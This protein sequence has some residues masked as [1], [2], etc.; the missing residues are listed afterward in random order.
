[1]KRYC[2]NCY[3]PLPKKA[4]FCVQCGQKNSDGKVRMRAMLLKL[5][6]TTFHLEGKF[7]RTCWQLFIPGKVTQEVFKGKQSR[8]PHPIRMFAIMMFLFLF[9]V[10]WVL[11]D[12]DANNEG[13]LISINNSMSAVNGDSTAEHKFSGSFYEKMRHRAMLEDMRAD[14]DALPSNWK[15]PAARKAVDSLL[16]SSNLRKG[17][18]ETGLLDSLELKED[19]IKILKLKGKE[20]R[21]AMMDLVRYE[22]DELIDRYAISE[23]YLKLA[24]RQF[25]KT[26]KSPDSLVHAYLGSLTWAILAQVTIMSGLLALFYWRQKRFFVEHFLFLLHFHTGLMLAFLLAII[27]I[28]LKFWGWSIFLGIFLW[29]AIAM[30]LGMRRY[31]EQSR[32]KTILKWM[33][34]GLFYYINFAVLLGLGFVL[35][36]A[37]Y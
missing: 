18:D 17:V 12:L 14:Y 29:A 36:L 27:G 33:V 35:V 13:T 37:S 11:K 8:Y 15:T 7:L 10:N 28:Q 5:W 24:L 6:N 9:M 20:F 32:T 23:W 19:S 26:I 1:M 22:P 25:V 16:R 31:Y 34:F 2:R 4:N 3:T 21:V 30:Y